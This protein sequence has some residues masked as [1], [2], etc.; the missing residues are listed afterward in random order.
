MP[1]P[2]EKAM[3][4]LRRARA[5]V[6]K[7]LSLHPDLAKS[8]GEVLTALAEIDDALAQ[9][10]DRQNLLAA[11]TVARRSQR[12]KPKRYERHNRG[13]EMFLAEYRPDSPYPFRVPKA[14]LD[15][16]VSVLA[17]SE[18]PLPIAD[19]R[20]EISDRLGDDPAEY[21]VHVCLR[22]LASGGL[23][24][25]RGRTYAPADPKAFRRKFGKL[26]KELPADSDL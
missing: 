20:S 6:A 26:W 24:R 8:V 5:S 11:N 2:N 4:A 1:D 22:L 23:T 12:S 18:R 17:T 14:T 13:G 25:V 15:T 7:L 19:L 9:V 3:A 10:H 16:V 21:Q